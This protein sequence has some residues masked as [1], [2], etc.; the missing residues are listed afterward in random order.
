MKTDGICAATAYPLVSVYC[1]APAAKI[2]MAE[3][4]AAGFEGEFNVPSLL[5]MYPCPAP[6]P[7]T[8]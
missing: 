6:L 3:P 5:R 2:V 1:P 7:S 4:A 8:E